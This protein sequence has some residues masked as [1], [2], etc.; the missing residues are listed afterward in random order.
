MLV[1]E[2]GVVPNIVDSLV[3][4]F[5]LIVSQSF[6]EVCIRLVAAHPDFFSDPIFQWS[7]RDQG[8]PDSFDER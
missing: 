5:K 7:D 3:Q 8:Y 2:G 1:V 4:F 6:E